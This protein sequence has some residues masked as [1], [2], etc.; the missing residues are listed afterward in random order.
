MIQKTI[1]LS[2]S[3]TTKSQR[4][5]HIRRNINVHIRCRHGK[6]IVK[7][8]REIRPISTSKKKRRK[9]RVSTGNQISDL[10]HSPDGMLIPL[11]SPVWELEFSPFFSDYGIQQYPLSSYSWITTIMIQKIEKQG[12]FSNVKSGWSFIKAQPL[13]KKRTSSINT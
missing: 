7:P 8:E 5:V 4:D 13:V 1:T 11:K 6:F 12:L 3:F 9:F 2:F 10:S